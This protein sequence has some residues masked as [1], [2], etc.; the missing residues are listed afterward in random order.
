MSDVFELANDDITFS[1]FAD[2]CAVAAL[3]LDQVFPAPCV[4]ADTLARP[5]T[6]SQATRFASC[7]AKQVAAM[8]KARFALVSFGMGDVVYVAATDSFYLVNPEAFAPCNDEDDGFVLTAVR[9]PVPEFAPNMSTVLPAAFDANHAQHCVANAVLSCLGRT[10]DQ[11]RGTKLGYFVER[12]LNPA[13]T[14]PLL[15]A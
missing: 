7:M 15:I 6:V 5:F 4:L 9:D 8:L 10:P 12:C 13:C 2:P 3:Q 1:V 14:V 11:L